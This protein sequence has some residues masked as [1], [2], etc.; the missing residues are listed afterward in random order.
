LKIIILQFNK[1]FWDWYQNFQISVY[2]PFGA[3]RHVCCITWVEVQ[4]SLQHSIC[5]ACV[6]ANYGHSCV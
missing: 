2:Q 5:A 6:L 3:E 4:I 1:K